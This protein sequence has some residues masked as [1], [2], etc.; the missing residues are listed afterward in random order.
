MFAKSHVS[1]TEEMTQ[2]IFIKF[3]SKVPSSKT[4]WSVPAI[5]YMPEELQIPSFKEY[6]S[7]KTNILADNESKILTLP[8]LGDDEPEDRQQV[9]RNDLPRRYEILHDENACLDLRQEQC[10]FYYD[11]VEAF[12]RSIGVTWDT[13]IYWLLSSATD[14]QRMNRASVRCDVFEKV[15]EDRAPYDK[16]FFSRDGN[17]LKTV[18]FEPGSDNWTALLYRLQKPSAEQLRVIALAGAALVRHCD[19]SPWYLVKRC[20]TMQNYVH[21]KLKLAKDAPDFTF[22][23]IICR[24]CHE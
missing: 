12:L 8:Y 16:E 14:L 23:D 13:M 21:A 3:T 17:D 9:L 5:T 22:R 6:V 2:E 19:F 18:L 7:L 4:I 20:K 24:I 15:V 1:N 10:N 11:T